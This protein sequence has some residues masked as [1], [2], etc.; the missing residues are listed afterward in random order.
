MSEYKE[1]IRQFDKIRTYVRD[2]Y[3]YGFKTRDD[4]REKS[5]RTYDNQRR[6]IESWFS[7]Y[8]RTD[9]KGHKK[10]VFLTLDS[11]RIS[12]NP[13][14]HAWKS[15]TFTDNDITLRFFLLDLLADGNFYSLE[16]I[17]DQINHTYQCLFDTQTIRRK[18]SSY[19]KEGLI[20]RR[21]EGRQYLYGGQ[22]DIA[23]TH[24]Q[25]MPALTLAVSF[26]QGAAPFGFIGSTILDFWKEENRYFRFRSDY[27]VHTLEDEILLSLIQAMEQKRQISLTIK[28]TRGSHTLRATAIPLKILTS[29]QTGRRYVCVWRQDLHRLSSLRLDSIHS[30]ELLDRDPCYDTH[31]QTFDRT[32]PFMWGV[33][34]GNAGVPETIRMNIRLDEQSEGYILSRLKREGRGGLLKR[35]EPGL[36]EYTRLCLDGAELLPWV[37]SFTGR[38]ASFHCSNPSVEKRLWD[39]LRIMAERY[40]IKEEK[41]APNSL[42]Q[43]DTRQ[44][45]DGKPGGK[46]PKA[47]APAPYRETSAPQSSPLFSELYSCY[48]Q[49]TA[50]ILEKAHSC[51]LTRSQITMLAQQY[52]YDESALSIVPKLIQGD[53]PLL[54]KEGSSPDSYGSLLKNP[55]Y[56]QPLTRLQ[57]SWLKSLLSDPRFRLFFTDDQIEEL[58]EL[59][60]EEKTLFRVRDFCLFDQYTDHDPFSSVMYRRH[61]HL[62]LK[63]M[64]E[65]LF[66]SVTYLSGKEN[67]ITRTWLPCRLEYGQKDGKF[68]FYGLAIRK[69]G[70]THMDILNVARIVSLKETDASFPSPVDV[71]SY[72]EHT[73]CREPLVLDI[74]T[75]R[76]ALE[77]TMLHF[78]CYEKK[79]EHLEDSGIYRCTIYYDKRWE[80]ELLI[81]VLSFGP[82][83][84]V[85]GPEPF[86]EQV[87]QRVALEAELMKS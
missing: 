3:V 83:I 37:K 74:T 13:L 65:R 51:P 56:P 44:E 64:E 46:S 80:T 53:W 69:N 77:R 62:L 1:L 61:I 84:T 34:M 36:Y 38:I 45:P 73:I 58:A 81:Q 19:E 87:R 79:V 40:L 27:L 86:L 63:A 67:L 66:L 5:G 12:M 59:L 6:R 32:L 78:S 70:R 16:G 23:R 35:L 85:L 75:Q 49:V 50:R 42:K 18:L 28:S 4:Y 57:R 39:D 10:S 48:Y 22:R 15:K 11:S 60:K 2:F 33:S 14:Y 55:V 25:L 9:L 8:I 71:D 82:V 31:M 21:K 41:G 29:T 68:R 26:F 52:G 30:A 72:L 7:E 17:A 20:M 43:A 24:P 76:N 47:P 54:K